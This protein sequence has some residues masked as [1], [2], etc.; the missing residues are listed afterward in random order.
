MLAAGLSQWSVAYALVHK[1]SLTLLGFGASLALR[2]A[3]RGLA[4]RRVPVPAQALLALP[5]SWGLAALW[6]AAHN[7]VLASWNA[8]ALD[9]RRFPDFDNAIYYAFLLVA[10]SGL[11]F[12][13]QAHF[14]HQEARLRLAEAEAHAA[15]ARLRALRLQLNPHF[16]FNAL[17]G[18]STLIAEGRTADA[19]RMLARLGDLLRDT[20]E[21]DDRAEVPLEDELALARRYLDVER[22]RFGDLLRVEVRAE[23]GAER[24]LVPALI[25]QP[26]VENA[27]KHAIAP[28][29]G[30]GA[31]SIR[32]RR[33]G[34][35]LTL[36]VDDDGPG[37][38]DGAPGIGLTTTRERLRALY[39]GNAALTLGAGE[40]GGAGVL[41]R[42]PYREAPEA[43]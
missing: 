2:A 38:R 26:L 25:L 14:A 7:L 17:N 30:A 31:V 34:A 18:V 41:I 5:L 10:W 37:I 13:I 28:R 1:T 42:L 15:A 27:V 33:E 12:G 35:D 23:R 6:M 39:G 19:N 11:Y 21:G 32:A 36:G 43:A 22:S 40:N 24:A 16:L 4:A 3:F 20:L 9:P 8:R 29:G